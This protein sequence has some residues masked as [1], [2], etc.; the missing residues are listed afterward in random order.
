MSPHDDEDAVT[1]TENYNG[2]VRDLDWVGQVRRP[3][4]RPAAADPRYG[5][6]RA[7]VVRAVT[8]FVVLGAFGFAA[9]TFM[10]F[11]FRATAYYAP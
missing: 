5:P 6:G 3:P 1:A 10:E 8:A 2:S 11:A 7:F 4:S 9:V